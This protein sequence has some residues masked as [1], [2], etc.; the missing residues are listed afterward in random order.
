[1]FGDQPF[2]AKVMETLQVADG[3]LARK[4]RDETRRRQNPLFWLDWAVTGLLGI[5]A[6]I[7]S[8]IIGVPVWKI[9]ES[10]VGFALRVVG[11]AVDGLIVYFGGHGLGWW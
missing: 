8:R 6:Y 4:E 3:Y 1:M 2:C 5:P 9:E 7:V 10:P 11:L